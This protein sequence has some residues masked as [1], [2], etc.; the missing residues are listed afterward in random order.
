[1][2]ETDMTITFPNG[3]QIIMVGLDTEEKLLSLTN[4]STV[5]VEEV[6]EVEKEKVEQLN[7]RMRGQAANQQIIL[8]W[9]PIS[10]NSYLYDFT[11]VNP[12][13]SSIY[14][15]ST[16]KDNPFLSDEYVAA[17]DEM[18]TR[19]PAKYRVYGL[20]EW[21]VD[22]EG[23][24]ITNWRMEEFD[25]MKL[26]SAGLPRRSGCD[27]GWIDPTAIIDSLYDKENK[28]IYVFNEFYKS[29]CQLSELAQ[30]LHDMN[31][32]KVKVFV[33]CAEPRAIQY[34]RSEGINASPCAKGKDSVKTGYQFL[35]DHLIVVHP[36]CQ[37]LIMELS[38]FCYIKSKQTGE[39]TEDTD[40]TFS[41]AIDGLR[42][43][44]ADIYTQTKLKTIS[45]SAFSL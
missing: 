25:P 7:L 34:F 39:W 24:V 44:Y 31:L 38:N 20:G 30:A 33:D 1:M 8:S 10:K 11:V 35:Q 23:L 36:S 40:H 6:F 15:H 21:G 12:P 9:N 13:E 28:T 29:G 14:H 41:H 43:A 3:S 37:K 17:L 32:T 2:R 42:Y 22:S 18:A 26:A 16:Y 45:K 4:I 27:V 5:W 19:N